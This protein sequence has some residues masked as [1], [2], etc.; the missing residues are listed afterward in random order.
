MFELG[1]SN[2]FATSAIEVANSFSF[3]DQV[4]TYG[5]YAIAVLICLALVFKLFD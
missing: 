5:L 1:I 4:I 2:S 3:L